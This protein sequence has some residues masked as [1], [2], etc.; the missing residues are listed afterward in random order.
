MNRKSRL[1]ICAW[2]ASYDVRAHITRAY[3]GVKLINMAFVFYLLA[4]S[5]RK[6]STFEDYHLLGTFIKSTVD[7]SI[8][9]VHYHY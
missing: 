2:E 7:C 5:K 4:V 3:P 8:S 1:L 9:I 6:K